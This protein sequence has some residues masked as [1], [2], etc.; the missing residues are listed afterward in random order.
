MFFELPKKVFLFPE[1]NRVKKCYHSSARI[2]KCVSEYAFLIS[3]N[4]NNT[5]KKHKNQKNERKK[6]N[7]QKKLKKK[8]DYP[9]KID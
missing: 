6:K 4:N 7:K 5:N 9:R 2:I 3:K 1:I 8:R